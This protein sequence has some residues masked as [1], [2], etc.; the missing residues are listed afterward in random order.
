MTKKIE[1]QQ[2]QINIG[3]G[4]IIAIVVLVG[5]LILAGWGISKY[6]KDSV[7]QVAA[8]QTL[9]YDCSEGQ[10]ALG[11]LKEKA[12]VKTQDSDYGVYVDEINGT[13]NDDGGFWIYYINGEM[14][15]VGAD[16]YSCQ[17]GDKIEW[18]FEKLY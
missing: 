15:E 2:N 4:N 6:S 8:A 7:P 9:D 13:A 5:L 18:R 11:V 17:D 1:N 10:T 12:E 3:L 14:G 16:Q